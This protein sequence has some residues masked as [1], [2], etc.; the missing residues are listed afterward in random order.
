MENIET[1]YT[2]VQNKD[3]TWQGIGLTEKAGKYQG[4]VY[5]YGEVKFS[6]EENPDGSLNLSFDWEMLDSN[7]LSQESFKD[8]FKNLIGDILVNILE[9]HVKEG[10]LVYDDRGD[11]TSSVDAQ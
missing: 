9:T 11:N 5:R 10:N 2:S 3:A 8:D 6:E 7:G 4:V 1:Y